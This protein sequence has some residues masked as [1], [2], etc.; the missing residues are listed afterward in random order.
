MRKTL[1]AVLLGTTL[2]TSDVPTRA[3]T[4][5]RARDVAAATA[6]EPKLSADVQSDLRAQ[7]SAAPCRRRRPPLPRQGGR[8]LAD[9]LREGGASIA[10]AGQFRRADDGTGGEAYHD[11]GKNP[12]IDATKDRLSTFAADV[13]YRVLSTIARR[14]LQ[15]GTPRPPAV[16]RHASRRSSTTSSMASRSL[17]SNTPFA[18]VMGGRAV[19]VA[20]AGRAHRARWR[21]DEGQVHDGAQ[22]RAPRV[23]RRR[24]GLDVERGQAR[25]REAGPRDPH[26]QP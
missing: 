25:S 26:P 3:R 2:L 19:A 16:R 10:V 23:P 14:K 17:A 12:W 8:I 24:V 13:D 21:R 9:K 1:A 4:C 15:E 20:Q 22:G 7:G 18:V 6:A 5:A 11:W